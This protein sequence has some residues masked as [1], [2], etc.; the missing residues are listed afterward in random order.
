MLGRS[1]WNTG[2]RPASYQCPSH[3]RLGRGCTSYLG[4]TDTHRESGHRP[5]LLPRRTRKVHTHR[6]TAARTGTRRHRRTRVHRPTAVRT[7]TR[8]QTYTRPQAHCGTHWDTS[9]QTHTRPQTH[10][11]THWNTSADAHACR[12]CTDTWTHRG[13]TRLTNLLLFKTAIVPVHPRCLREDS[14][15]SDLPPKGQDVGSG[16]AG[17]EVRYVR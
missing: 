1:Y 16:V 9:V 3:W 6:P 13:T 10:R 7:G 8:R 12:T 5:T 2:A 14:T 15:Q 4:V 11:G 17:P